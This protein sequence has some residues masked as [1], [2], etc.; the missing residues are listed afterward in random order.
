[1]ISVRG[2]SKRYR[3]GTIGMTSLRDELQRLW[4]SPSSDQR[5]SGEFWA[6]KDITFDVEP[7]EESEAEA[8]YQRAGGD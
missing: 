3:L 4:R 6:L 7:G 2:V 8:C 1:M 5:N